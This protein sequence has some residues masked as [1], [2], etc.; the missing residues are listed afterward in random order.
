[1]MLQQLF[2]GWQHKILLILLFQFKLDEKPSQ[3][4]STTVCFGMFMSTVA[5]LKVQFSSI[6][7]KSALVVFCSTFDV[8]FSF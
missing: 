8:N 6:L 5:L 7:S 2:E 3:P 4:S 1:M